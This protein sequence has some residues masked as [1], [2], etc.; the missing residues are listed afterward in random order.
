MAIFSVFERKSALHFQNRQS[1]NGSKR[2]GIPSDSL[3]STTIHV[4]LNDFVMNDELRMVQRVDLN[5]KYNKP[6]CTVTS[7]EIDCE[8]LVVFI[9]ENSGLVLN[10]E[11]VLV[12]SRSTVVGS[13]QRVLHDLKLHHLW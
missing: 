10:Q 2:K 12:K 3:L 11:Q 5:W 6:F 4:D 9:Q 8:Y 13:Q 7:S 1:E